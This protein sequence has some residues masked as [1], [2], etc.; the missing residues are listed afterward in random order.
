M[1]STINHVLYVSH[2]FSSFLPHTFKILFHSFA[3][4][5]IHAGL[6]VRPHLLTAYDTQL[7][8][9]VTLQSFARMIVGKRKVKA[10]LNW[11]TWNALDNR[12]EHLQL[13][14]GKKVKSLEHGLPNVP[15]ALTK[16]KTTLR[17]GEW[18]LVIRHLNVSKVLVYI[19]I[20]CR[21]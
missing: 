11:R 17:E 16:R 13:E 18:I 6:F 21:S 19:L 5:I 4:F 12:N 20:Q 1:L 14:K 3:I 7:Q 15:S 9:A 2:L 8:A 10:E